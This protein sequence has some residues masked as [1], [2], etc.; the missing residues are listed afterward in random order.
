MNC[1]NLEMADSIKK[2]LGLNAKW[3]CPA[4]GDCAY[5]DGK[6]KEELQKVGEEYDR[7]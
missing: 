7:T 2:L 3:I 6:M 5:F 1:D 4:H